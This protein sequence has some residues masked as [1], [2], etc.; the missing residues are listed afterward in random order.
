MRHVIPLKAGGKA[1]KHVVE[2]VARGG[3]WGGRSLMVVVRR[4]LRFLV[5][6]LNKVIIVLYML[7]L[8]IL[9]LLL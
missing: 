3:V 7:S 1:R 4:V 5:E 8:L 9:L 6:M 2:G